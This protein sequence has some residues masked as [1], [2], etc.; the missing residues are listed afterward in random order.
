MPSSV[1]SFLL[2]PTTSAP[3]QAPSKSSKPSRPPVPTANPTSS[4][5]PT[6]CITGNLLQTIDF[7]D[8]SLPL[9]V[10]DV[11]L[12]GAVAPWTYQSEAA[13]SGSSWGIEAGRDNKV[14]GN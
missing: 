6:E 10:T 5:A 1:P 4:L 14:S 8:P 3:T 2:E 12:T 7:E 9:I 13:C 11:P